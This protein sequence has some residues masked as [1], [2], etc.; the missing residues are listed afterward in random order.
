MLDAVQRKLGNKSLELSNEKIYIYLALYQFCRY[1]K[2]HTWVD[3]G[4]LGN[5][6]S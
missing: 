5:Y 3:G 6:I 2:N 4:L 1:E